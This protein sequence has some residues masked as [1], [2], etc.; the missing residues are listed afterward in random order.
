MVKIN[1]LDN[2]DRKQGLWFWFWNETSVIFVK[3]FY[4]N[5]RLVNYCMFFLPIGKFD[6]DEFYHNIF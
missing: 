6:E 3:C 1:Q 2:L 5:D 4:L